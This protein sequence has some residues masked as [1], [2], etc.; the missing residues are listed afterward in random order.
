MIPGVNEG[1]T[2]VVTA[3]FSDED[4]NAVIPTSASYRVDDAASGT[5]VIAATAV[6][7]TAA[8]IDIVIPAA[9]NMILNAGRSLEQRV[10]TVTFTYSGGKTGTGEYHYHVKNLRGIT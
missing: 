8:V 10:L 2:H 7:P 3:S 1:S 4:G 5:V 6:T 9:K